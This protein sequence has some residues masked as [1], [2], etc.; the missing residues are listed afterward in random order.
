MFRD[1]DAIRVHP[2]ITR[3]GDLVNVVPAD[4]R[5]ETFV[6]GKTNDAIMDANIKVDRA[7]RAGALAIGARVEINTLPGYMPLQDDRKMQKLFLQNA[8]MLFGAEE[9]TEAGH[10]TGSTDMGDISHIMP[11]VH[12]SMSGATGISHGN[13]FII[14]DKDMAYMAPA[15]ALAL[16]AVDLLYDNAAKAKEI[17]DQHKPI[18]SKDEYLAYQN[19]IFQKEIFDGEKG[20]SEKTTV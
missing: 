2:I 4:V 17:Q 13:D 18:M 5:L 1:E 20:T 12:P 15:K 10:R 16:M 6:R 3:G 7:L 19:R 8:Q 11:S 9:C 14:S